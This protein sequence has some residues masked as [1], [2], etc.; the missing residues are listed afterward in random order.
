MP[1]NIMLKVPQANLMQ[2]KKHVEENGGFECLAET[3]NKVYT[4]FTQG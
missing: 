1:S 4:K 3:W 2:K